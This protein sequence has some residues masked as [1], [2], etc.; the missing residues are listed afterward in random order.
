MNPT[1]SVVIPF[2][3]EAENVRPLWEGVTKSLEG[4]AT[5]E[6]VFV[7]D[8]SSDGT[9]AALDRL[10]AKDSRLRPIHFVR[11]A[12]Q[13]AALIAGMHAARDARR[14]VMIPVASLRPVFRRFPS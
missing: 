12:G 8:G 1:V 14:R 4:L 3:N 9:A 5:Y 7:D 2:Y 11:N 6:C 10:A 13:S